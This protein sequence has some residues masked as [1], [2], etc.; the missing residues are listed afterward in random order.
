MARTH[1]YLAAAY[2]RTE[3]HKLARDQWEGL[4]RLASAPAQLRCTGTLKAAQHALT[5]KEYLKAGELLEWCEPSALSAAQWANIQCLHAKLAFVQNRSGEVLERLSGL[6][7]SQLASNDEFDVQLLHSEA[8]IA[9]RKYDLAKSLLV[10][11]VVLADKEELRA[12]L[13][14]LALRRC[15]VAML[16]HRPQEAAELASKA[17]AAYP[18]S[19]EAG[20]LEIIQG[21]AAIANA[22]FITAR[23]HFETVANSSTAER[24]ST[25]AKAAWFI[26][27]TYFLS[28]DY[29]TAI[30]A[31]SQVV[32]RFPTSQWAAAARLQR[33]KCFELTFAQAAAIADYQCILHDFPTTTWQAQATNRLNEL[34][35]GISLSR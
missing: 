11:L 16:Q 25:A 24:T 13:P 29:P 7:L 15:E 26:G 22:E 30:H 6:D 28:R 1:L 9:D 27:E 33:G 17:Q 2:D 34:G 4:A 8:A 10:Q 14:T 32:D 21:R 12:Y 23:T 5:Q 35:I 19:E 18:E 20:E 31:Y 3:Q